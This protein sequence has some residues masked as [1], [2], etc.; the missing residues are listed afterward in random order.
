[1]T[2]TLVLAALIAQSAP[3]PAAPAAASFERL[4]QEA[5]AA[6]S[7]GR[8]LEAISLYRKALKLKPDWTKGWWG[9]GALEYA[10]GNYVACRDALAELTRLDRQA[11]AGWALRGICEYETKDYGPALSDLYRARQIAPGKG[12]LSQAADHYYARLLARRG[13]YESALMVLTEIARAARHDEAMSFSCGVAALR[14]PLLPE[15]VNSG[16]REVVTLAGTAFWL[17]ATGTPAEAEAA[18]RRL[19]EAYPRFPNVNYFFGTWLTVE[20]PAA[21]RDAFLKELE[22]TPKHAPARTRL[23]LIDLD[24]GD[25]DGAL[26]FAAQAVA[27]DPQYV[28]A[29]LARGRSLLQ[30]G[31]A[32]DAVLALT[33]ARDLDPESRQ[34]RLLLM[35][36]LRESGRIAEAERERR[37][38]Q[39]LTGAETP[40]R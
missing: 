40:T 25:I 16:D 20:R 33:R 18:Y 5:Q 26:R 23:A 6:H 3:R 9:L 12:V 27:D 39:R 32:K 14:L 4:A 35:S 37:E 22:I 2:A 34:V 1:M 15:E 28:P 30:A 10:Q 8:D 21:A 24:R 11:A 13:G 7:D 17:T 29:H 38:F 36:A 19:L 31:Q